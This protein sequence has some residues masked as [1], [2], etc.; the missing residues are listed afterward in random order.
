MREESEGKE[1]RQMIL[2]EVMRPPGAAAEVGRAGGEVRQ[3][4]ASE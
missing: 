4:V 3:R 1:V 2:P